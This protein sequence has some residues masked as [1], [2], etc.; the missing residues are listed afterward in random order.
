MKKTITLITAS[1]GFLGAA[2]AQDKVN[3]EKQ[4]LPVLEEKCIEC[5]K[6]PYKDERGRTKKPKSGLRLD[7][8]W[9]YAKG[10]SIQ[11]DENKKVLTP[12]KPD[13]STLYSFTNLP[14]DDDLFMPPKGDALTDEEKALLK[15]WIE[16]GA[17]FGDWKGNEEGKE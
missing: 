9:G 6:A 5:H 16:E 13:E 17:E 1:F 2:G 10:G 14:E 15:R 4:L 12:G 3:F 8:A 11:E 7:G